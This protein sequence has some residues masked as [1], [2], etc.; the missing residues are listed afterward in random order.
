MTIAA[1]GNEA[2]LGFLLDEP[3]DGF[4]LGHPRPMTP[5]VSAP[6]APTSATNG[7]GNI[8]ATVLYKQALLTY[9]GE[10]TPSTA[11]A[12]LACTANAVTVTIGSQSNTEVIARI[13]YRSHD[14]G[15]TYYWV[16][17]VWDRTTTTF[18][19]DL[20]T[21]SSS[22]DTAKVP[23]TYNETGANWGAVFM[24]PESWNL[25]PSYK[26]I[27]TKE[28]KGSTG[29]SRGAP[30][31]IDIQV[32]LKKALESGFIVPML[33]L[34]IGKPTIVVNAD[35]TVK[36][37]FTPST[38]RRYPYSG[39]FLQWEGGT[40]RPE[41]IISA[42]L[43]DIDIDVK[44][45]DIVDV[46]PKGM[47][48]H[49]TK[50]GM[51]KWSSTPNA[52]YGTV[53]VVKGN[54][55]DA[56]ADTT[57]I[58]VKVTT[59]P[60]AGTFAIKCKVGSGASYGSTAITITYDTTSKKQIQTGSQ[61]S[62]YVELL[63]STSG[64]RYG[65]D[66]GENRRPF[67][68][69]FPGDCTQIALNDEWII[70][71]PNN[72]LAPGAGSTP[73]TPDSSFTGFAPRGVAKARYTMCH[74]TLLR[75]TTL[76]TPSTYVEIDSAKV[77]LSWPIAATRPLG[78]E[79]ASP[80]DFDRNDFAKLGI[81]FSRRFVNRLFEG[82]QEQDTRIAVRLLLQ[83]EYPVVQPGT[84]ASNRLAIQIDIPQAR[85]DEANSP[86]SGPNALHETVSID[87]EQPDD[88]TYEPFT[89]TITDGPWHRWNFRS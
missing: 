28:L 48:R 50:S 75:G 87:A 12:G 3:S 20:A 23:K 5:I 58:Y 52:N 72:A 66:S 59:A 63:D 53:P 86:V 46:Q 67:M 25:D 88:S 38:A 84:L 9:A 70:P 34:L 85:V 6:S 44:G 83:G 57:D 45:G 32:A 74:A 81:D 14:A 31:L 71:A 82:Y 77:K 4:S 35:G 61:P 30:G 39:T 11:A 68:I 89:I 80:V 43:S 47:A 10:T 37:T 79:A 7:A 49:H 26:Q 2:L 33:G 15:A 41:I 69:M 36:Y 18:A 16:G 55:S 13:I 62:D 29:M 73:G 8:T 24:W 22:I 42:M 1:R 56:S 76:L 40:L 78:G 17:S 65:A 64:S 19:D 51:T 60:S 21:T 27:A 54:R